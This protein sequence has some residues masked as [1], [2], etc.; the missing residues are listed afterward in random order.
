MNEKIPT[1][2]QAVTVKQSR[3]VQ[4]FTLTIVLLML[5]ACASLP[6][7]YPRS[8]S[9]ALDVD[10]AGRIARITGP[11]IK[12]HPGQSGIYPLVGGLDSL[13][14]RLA[15]IDAAE[16][17]ID[18]QYY[19]WHQDTTGYLL[20]GR[21]L[22]AADRGVRVRLLLDDLGSIP[23]DE[24]L[25]ALDSH[26]NIE[27]RIFNPTTGRALSFLSVLFEFTRINGRM[28]NK[29][30]T[31]DSQATIIG[32]RN[33]GDEYFEAHEE[34]DFADL[35]VLAIGA[36]VREVAKSFDIYWNNKYAVPITVTARR[37]ASPGG[38]AQLRKS[39]IQTIQSAPE[40]YLNDLDDSPLALILKDRRVLPL[41]WAHAHAL[42]DEPGKV[43]NDHMK[44]GHLM[45][46]LEPILNGTQRELVIVSPY[47]IPGK[48]GLRFL[49]RLSQQGARVRVITNSITATDIFAVHA[50]YTRYRRALLRAGVEIYEIKSDTPV[51]TKRKYR[52]RKRKE[53]GV[54]ARP[55][56][57]LHAKAYVVD[58]QHIFVGSLNFDPRSIDI[59]TEIG[60]LID[61]A[62]LAGDVVRRIE[63]HLPD[64]AYRLELVKID[65][66]NPGS[67]DRIEWVSLEDGVEKRYT[68]EPHTNLLHRIVMWFVSLPP[69]QSQL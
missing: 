33:I 8:E 63:T 53:S 56:A 69:F 22:E 32:G 68:S 25:L 58:R 67:G 30:L 66:E 26:P 55:R 21:L 46:L 10:P 44:P 27:V 36:V 19:I 37:Q 16:R 7:D 34:L 49:S 39:L 50:S 11:E 29:S 61:S 1:T 60:L 54:R 62:A 23:K 35:D 38:L 20:L 43:D 45:P 24:S 3:T 52:K 48:S 65:P 15:L 18:T 2:T 42:Y 47:F 4:G 14:A 9:Y 40:E 51:W 5:S 12:R 17:S 41:V 13:A 6:K 57:S 28:H 59:N 64:S 31:V